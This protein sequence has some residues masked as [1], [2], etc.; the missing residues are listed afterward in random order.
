MYNTCPHK[1]SDPE[2]RLWVKC[3]GLVRT[4]YQLPRSNPLGYYYITNDVIRIY[5]GF[6][7]LI[8]NSELSSSRPA[9]IDQISSPGDNLF[10][11]D[12]VDYNIGQTPQT[13]SWYLSYNLNSGNCGGNAYAG[14]IDASKPDYFKWN[15]LDP[16]GGYNF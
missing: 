8:S 13:A 2:A 1:L 10:R 7:K 14:Q 11:L 12:V 5:S 9:Y 16:N 6:A 3:N 4:K 15:F